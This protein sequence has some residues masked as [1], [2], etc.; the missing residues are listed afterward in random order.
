MTDSNY[1]HITFILDNSSSMLSLRPA[2]LEGF[3]SF[4]AKQKAIP[5]KLT[6]SL[7][8]FQGGY[9]PFLSG[10]SIATPLTTAVSP[11]Q[12]KTPNAS[13][14]PGTFTTANASV[15]QFPYGMSPSAP[16]TVWPGGTDSTGNNNGAGGVIG[17]GSV[18]PAAV[19]GGGGGGSVVTVVVELFDFPKPDQVTTTFEFVDIGTVPLLTEANYPCNT[20]TPLLDAMGYGLDR[21]GRLLAEMDE[22][23]R[24]G[25]VLFVI[26]T[27]GAENQSRSYNHA[28]V[29]AKIKHQTDVYGW[30]FVFL[31]ANQDAIA[32]GGSYGISAGSSMSYA[33]DS[34]SVTATFNAISQSA[35]VLRTM[36]TPVFYNDATRKAVMDGTL[37]A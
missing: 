29:T 1:T 27:D 11:G 9:S 25:K 7:Y 33:A 17:G 37:Q 2:T 28:G 32:V 4:I 10:M 19:G 24:P 35:E 21:T 8:Q 5:G 20:M 22:A 6:F 12:F 3:N 23:S 15:G 18:G 36:G 26:L 13:V 16:I 31:G 30:E 34:S 14:S